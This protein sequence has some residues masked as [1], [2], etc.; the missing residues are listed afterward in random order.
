MNLKNGAIKDTLWIYLCLI[1][2]L[3]IVLANTNTELLLESNLSIH[4]IVEHSI[5]F[6]IGILSVLAFESLLKGLVVYEHRGNRNRISNLEKNTT[7]KYLSLVD[8][9]RFARSVFRLNRYGLIW[10]FFSMI[11]ITFW[12]IPFAFDLANENA[13]VHI[14]QHISFILVGLSAFVGIR[15]LG[16]NYLYFIIFMFGGMMALCGLIFIVLTHRIYLYYSI[17]GHNEAG[18]YMII[19]SLITMLGL[20]PAYIIRDARKKVNLES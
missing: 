6:A 14:L 19:T 10:I 4:M 13:N 18:M 11:L 3:S 15:S 16:E 7:Q 2:F 9:K 1:V 8:C 17:Y 5:F 20:F 12:H